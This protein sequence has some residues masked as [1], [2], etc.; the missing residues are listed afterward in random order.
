MW[1]AETAVDYPTLE[2]LVTEGIKLIIQ[3]PSQAQR[4]RPTPPDASDGEGEPEWCEV[5]GG[6]IDATRPYRC[7]LPG[8]AGAKYH[9]FLRW[10]DFA[11]HGL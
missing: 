6:Q 4:C 1:R 5:G 8:S 2:A 11:G 7:F 10:P 3:A 9:L